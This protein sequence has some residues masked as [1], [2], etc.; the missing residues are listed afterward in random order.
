LTVTRWIIAVAVLLGGLIFVHELGH[1]LVA[2]LFDVKVLRFSLGFGPKLLSWVVGST[3]YRLALFP[4][5]G[6]VRL[7]GEDPHDP[8]AEIDRDRTLYAKPLWQRYAIVV[9]GPAFN[10]LL[11]I[12]IYFFQYVGQRT[13]LP[14][15]I[16]TVLSGL[17]A[18]DAGLLPGDRVETVDGRR[19]R[20]W[21]ELEAVIAASPERTLRLGIRRG[22]DAEERD[23]TPLR[24]ERPGSL[25]MMEVVGMAG[26]LP[27]FHLAEV[28]I[29][30]MTSPAW[31]AGLR[32]FDDVVAVNGL[33]VS[34]WAEFEKAVARAGAAPLRIA[35]LRGTRSIVPFAHVE[36][37]EPGTAVVIPQP[38]LD[39]SGRRRYETGLLSSDLFVHSVEPGS[40]ADRIGIRHGDQLLELDGKPLRHWNLLTQRL[41]AAPGRTFRIT[42]VSPGGVRHEASF[43]Q[44]T[45]SQIDAYRQEQKRLVFGA[46]NRFAWKTDQPVPVRNRFFYALGHALGHTGQIV[47]VMSQGFVQIIRGEIPSSSLLGPLGVGYI[48]GVAA[49][50]GLAQYLRLMALLSINLGLLNFLPI[51]ILDGGLLMFFTI[52]LIKGRPPSARARQIASYVGLVVVVLLMALALKNDLVR[53]LLRG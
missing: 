52:E 2:R 36:L 46:S 19:I 43:T 5:G 11:P 35:Y 14:P 6:Y 22:D 42:W 3:E 18:A 45:R 33:P 15:T 25:G 4:L 31:Q 12:G 13:V 20:Y 41:L 10:L 30:E 32:T 40:P 8:V 24:D 7:L 48:A 38:V 47:V 51:P 34:H 23:V 29:I 44:E 26:I 16:G 9:A 53:L 28:G 39:G 50:Q 27:R 17:P 49:E 37:Q 1:F 21:E